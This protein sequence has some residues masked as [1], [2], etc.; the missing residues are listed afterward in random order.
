MKVTAFLSSDTH[1]VGVVPEEE[2]TTTTPSTL[3]TLGVT[4]VWG[5]GEG[6]GEGHDSSVRRGE[7]K[8]PT[9]GKVN[10]R[11]VV[12][13]VQGWD[14][15]PTLVLLSLPFLFKL[16]TVSRVVQILPSGCD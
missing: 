7:D 9:G 12:K 16:S 5:E 13:V 1:G 3:G 14:V 2:K 4:H 8:G 10:T 6:P 11:V 15:V